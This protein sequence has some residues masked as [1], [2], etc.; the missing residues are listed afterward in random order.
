[1]RRMKKSV[2]IIISLVCVFA[3][4]I[5]ISLLAGFDKNVGY[6][7]TLSRFFCFLPFFVAGF[8]CGHQPENKKITAKSSIPIG[9]LCIGVLIVAMYHILSNGE[10]FSRN[11]LYGS[12]SYASEDYTYVERGI[13]LITGF[14]WIGMLFFIMPKKK[15][16]VISS[17]GKNT[18]PVFLFH[19][20]V[21]RLLAK[22]RVFQYSQVTNLC[23]AAGIALIVVL[24]LGNSVTAWLC[25]WCFTGHW[26]RVLTGKSSSAEKEHAL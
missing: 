19:G 12:Y 9:V 21:M 25:K 7:M 10:L 4:A 18:L 17:V 22:E 26:L 23:L 20:F 3:V 24:L 15:L 2:K 6:Y 1:M 8:Y 11:V 14:A 13:L 5:A 16:P